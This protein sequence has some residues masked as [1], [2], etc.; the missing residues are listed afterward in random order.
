MER[1]QRNRARDT[2]F[3]DNG[4]ATSHPIQF[5]NL[6]SIDDDRLGILDSQRSGLLEFLWQCPRKWS[7]GACLRLRNVPERTGS[8]R[9]GSSIC[10]FRF[11][12]TESRTYWEP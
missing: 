1:I 12:G 10:S 4:A 9:L 7:C 5:R 2:R 6:G 3:W 8:E 11:S